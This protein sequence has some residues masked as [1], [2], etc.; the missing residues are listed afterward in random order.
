MWHDSETGKRGERP[1]FSPSIILPCPKG[2]GK[3]ICAPARS[4]VKKMKARLELIGDFEDLKTIVDFIKEH[5]RSKPNKP[6]DR[7]SALI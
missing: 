1:R 4:Y 7:H 3:G 5:L 2:A 6:P